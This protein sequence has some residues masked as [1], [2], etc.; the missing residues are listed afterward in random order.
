[1]YNRLLINRS[2]VINILCFSKIIFKQFTHTEVII[3]DKYYLKRLSTH[4]VWNFQCK[5]MPINKGDY[6][7]TSIQQYISKGLRGIHFSTKIADKFLLKTSLYKI[8]IFVIK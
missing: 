2:N 1:M 6:R 5:N 4:I 7:E 3:F 8:N